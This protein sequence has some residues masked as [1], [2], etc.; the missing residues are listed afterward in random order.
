MAPDSVDL[1]TWTTTPADPVAAIAEFKTAVRAR[2]RAAGRSIDEVFAVMA[3][4][5]T[6]QVREIAAELEQ[7]RN[8]WPVVEYA[9]I[10]AGT[11]PVDVVSLRS[12]PTAAAASASRFRRRSQPC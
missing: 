10:E 2:L 8:M 6:A 11:V 3:E 7:G 9:D 12:T 1:P 5:V 4:R